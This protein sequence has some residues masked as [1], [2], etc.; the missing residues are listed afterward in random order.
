MTDEP[1]ADHVFTPIRLPCGREAPNRLMK[2]SMYEHAASFF[3]GPPNATHIGM[4]KN[5]GQGRWGLVL[6]GNVQ[7]DKSHLTIGRDMIIPDVLNETTL[8]PFKDLA[9]AIHGGSDGVVDPSHRA[10]A[11]MQV[12][13]SGRQSANWIAGRVPWNPPLAPSSVRLGARES[14]FI[15]QLFYRFLFSTPKEMTIPE[16]DH[17][18]ERFV[19][20]AKTAYQ[21]G[22]EGIE[23]H[24]GHGC[25]CTLPSALRHADQL[26]P[27]DLISQFISEKSNQRTDEYGEKLYLLRRVATEVRRNVPK[28]FVVGVKLNSADF[29]D[30][31][32]VT[33]SDEK[34]LQ[35]VREIASW[36]FIDFLEITGGDYESPEFAA[37][38][39]KRQVFFSQFSRRVHESLP[40]GPNTPLITLTGGFRTY[41]T[42]NSA[43][44][45]GHAELIGIGRLSIHD[46]QVPVQLESEKHDYVPPP[47]PIFTVSVWDRLLDGLGWLT[48]VKVP[49]LMGAG[50][51]LC[52]YM[53][54]LGNVASFTPVDYGT[55]GFGAMLRS[56]GGV[57]IRSV[58]DHEVLSCS[59]YT[60]FVIFISWIGLFGIWN[61]MV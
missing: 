20:S 57:K 41:T 47:P 16:I 11:I 25:K 26:R 54:Q 49:L 2:A 31:K 39:S 21:A 6:T 10:L 32:A 30:R 29:V 50:R 48:G 35:H 5:W 45:N 7:V 34:A 42:V 4:Y 56:V 17:L 1:Q 43:L 61:A 12:S 18:V 51:E 14:G 52:W 13:H 59:S 58:N 40:K 19:L 9:E 37:S 46:P 44:A 33:T 36:G 15:P 27:L 3:G 23:V 24:A 60:L 28:D 8:R 22:F 53:I 55:S 38:V